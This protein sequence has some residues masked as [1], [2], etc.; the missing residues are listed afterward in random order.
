MKINTEVAYIEQVCVGR[1]GMW[2]ISIYTKS[3]K[4][5]I[6]EY[7]L[8]DTASEAETFASEHHITLL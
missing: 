4:R 2:K 5:K 3:T 1:Y 7:G 8:F 6:T